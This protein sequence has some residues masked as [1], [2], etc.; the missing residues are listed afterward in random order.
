MTPEATLT[1]SV[2]AAHRRQGDGARLWDLR[3]DAERRSGMPSGAE[4]VAVDPASDDAL[5]ALAG[6]DDSLLLIC[7]SGLRSLRAAERLRAIGYRRVASVEGGVAAWR[8]AGLPLDVEPLWPDAPVDAAERYDR[9]LRLDGVGASGQARLAR[10]RVLLIGAGGLGSPIALYLAAA[11]VGH[12]RLVDDDVV[13]RSNLQRQVLHRDAD[14][15]RAKVDSAR[16]RL[17]ALNPSIDVDVRRERLSA[18]TV[19]ALVEGIDVVVD[20]S[21]NFPA[22]YLAN[23]ACV[24]H[25]LPLVHGA[26]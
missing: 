5:R 15:G 16:E 3:S 20:G 12:L 11:G 9:H 19:D 22:R 8:A 26:V 4:A 24:R 23:A 10:S 14:V 6:P 25:G 21:D 7:A 17:L 18:S 1:V 2:E 13:D